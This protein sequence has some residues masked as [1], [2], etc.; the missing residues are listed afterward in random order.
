LRGAT[1]HFDPEATEQRKRGKKKV[2]K[3]YRVGGRMNRT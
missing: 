1:K 3:R 2:E